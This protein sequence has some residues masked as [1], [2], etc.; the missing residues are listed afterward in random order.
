M[1]RVK[2]CHICGKSYTGWRCPC[3]KKGTS[4]SARGRVSVGCSTRSWRLEKARARM[5]GGWN[6]PDEEQDADES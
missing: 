6:N 4:R 2:R 3:R 1:T 5:L